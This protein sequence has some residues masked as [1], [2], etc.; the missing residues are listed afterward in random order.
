MTAAAVQPGRPLYDPRETLEDFRSRQREAYQAGKLAWRDGTISGQALQLYDELVR[1]VGANKFGWIKEETLAA[2]L[3]RSVSTVKRWMS[4]LVR[5]RLIRRDRRF[6]GSSLTYITAYDIGDTPEDQDTA[7]DAPASTEEPPVADRPAAH[8]TPETPALVEQ[9][10]ADPAPADAAPDAFFAPADAPSIS[11]VVSRHTLTQTLNP[12]GGGLQ[13]PAATNDLVPTTET[14][15]RLQGEGVCAPQVLEEL[16]VRPLDQVEAAIRYVARCR[17]RDDPR[18]PGLIVY[19]LRRGFGLGRRA[20]SKGK[21][22]LTPPPPDPMTGAPVPGTSDGANHEL[23]RQW[24]ATLDLLATQIDPEAYAT[25]MAHNRLLLV[26]R[27]Q[28]VIST[29]NVFVRDEVIQR[30]GR[31]LETALSQVYGR[32][33]S[34][35]LVIGTAL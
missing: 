31:E 20:R 19:L 25:W 7:D 21:Q 2:L 9:I 6:G 24:Q 17:S 32:S 16:H 30:Y 28:A 13:V 29:P 23:Q 15:R 1:V 11:S 12:A 35:E 8:G 18:R 34:I 4:Q 33:L 10:G 22:Q 3:V 14:T 27:D 26:E 5:A